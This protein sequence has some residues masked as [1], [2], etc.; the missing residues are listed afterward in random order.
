MSKGTM[1]LEESI[2]I[3]LSTGNSTD[4]TDPLGRPFKSLTVNAT[5]TAADVCKV[6][7][8]KLGMTPLMAAYLDVMEFKKGQRMH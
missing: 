1:R 6:M 5:M 7:A 4:N 8:E 2:K 3:Y